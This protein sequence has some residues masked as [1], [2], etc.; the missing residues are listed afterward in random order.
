MSY[1][2]K[3]RCSAAFMVGSHASSGGSGSW[4]LQRLKIA[5]VLGKQQ[6]QVVGI[7]LVVLRQPKITLK[8]EEKPLRCDW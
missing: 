4:R 2:D 5:E 3:H 1:G 6:Q 8:M 7:N